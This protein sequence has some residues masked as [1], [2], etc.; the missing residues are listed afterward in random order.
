METLAT[1]VCEY[2]A[3]GLPVI[4]NSQPYN[5]MAVRDYGFGLTVK[6]GNVPELI[7]AL[8]FL[9]RDKPLAKSMGQ[10]GYQAFL[11]H[12]NWGVE[13]QKLLDLYREIL[14]N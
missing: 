8:L 1:K 5:D 11:S 12:Y 2:M 13:E 6:S 10:K 3:V 9:K 4:L 7:K 14:S